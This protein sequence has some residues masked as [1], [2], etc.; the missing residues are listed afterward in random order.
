VKDA[1]P[2]GINPKILLL[3]LQTAALPG[4]WPAVIQPVP[5]YYVKRL[6]EQGQY[7]SVHV[8]YP[9]GGVVVDTIVDAGAGPSLLGDGRALQAV[10][11]V[12]GLHSGNLRRRWGHCGLA[13]GLV[14]AP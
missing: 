12:T 5:G 1:E 7:D 2:Q 13:L 10:P 4:I 8:L 6:Y 14:S 11:A 9:G 3:E